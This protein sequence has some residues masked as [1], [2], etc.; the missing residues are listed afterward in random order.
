MYINGIPILGC[1]TP[2]TIKN[3]SRKSMVDVSEVI[4]SV[5]DELACGAAVLTAQE[6]HQCLS[7]SGFTVDDS[8]FDKESWS[9]LDVIGLGIELKSQGRWSIAGNIASVPLADV[10]LWTKVFASMSAAGPV[11][12]GRLRLSLTSS[13]PQ[14]LTSAVWGDLCSKGDSEELVLHDFLRLCRVV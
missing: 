11:T 6:A 3:F 8:M 1:W 9:L 4:T 7:G 13:G 2:N 14:P 5:F 10:L 12:A